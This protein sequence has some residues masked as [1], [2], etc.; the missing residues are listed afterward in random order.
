LPASGPSSTAIADEVEPIPGPHQV[1]GLLTTSPNAFVEP[2]HPKA[3]PVI[4]MTDE[5]D[6]W[7]R[8]AWDEAKLLQ[9]RLP[10]DA[11]ASSRGARTRK[12]RPPNEIRITPP[13]FGPGKSPAHRRDP[14]TPR[15]GLLPMHSRA[16]DR[17]GDRAAA[18][19]VGVG[20]LDAAF[21]GTFGTDVVASA[22]CSACCFIAWIAHW[23]GPLHLRLFARSCALRSWRLVPHGACL[24]GLADHAA[25]ARRLLRDWPTY[26]QLS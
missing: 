11:S 6:V 22:R 3:M 7:I 10:D 4:L 21:A 1:Y 23:I 26:A 25:P 24:R 8:A 13:L 9:R 18:A 19:A 20:T 2:I 16:A 12:T 14:P 5:R 17:A 15:M